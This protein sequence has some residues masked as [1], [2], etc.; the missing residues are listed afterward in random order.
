MLSNPLL[1]PHLVHER[2][3]GCFQDRLQPPALPP[4]TQVDAG[5][6]PLSARDCPLD[7]ACSGTD[8]ARV[9]ETLNLDNSTALPA[10]GSSPTW[11]WKSSAQM[12]A[13]HSRCSR[14]PSLQLGRDVRTYHSASFGNCILSQPFAKSSEKCHC[15]IEVCQVLSGN[16]YLYG[17]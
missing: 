2:M 4:A 7:Q 15:K 16:G 11:A 8:V 3:T 17:K 6:R 5:F 1:G 13:R 12:P 9:H 10:G 14:S